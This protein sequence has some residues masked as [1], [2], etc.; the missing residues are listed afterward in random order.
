[1]V[2][3]LRIT[4]PGDNLK[5]SC[6]ETFYFFVRKTSVGSVYIKVTAVLEI[7]GKK[8]PLI[9]FSRGFCELFK[10]DIL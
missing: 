9:L 10:F 3:L 7:Y 2:L 8:L 1:M 6:F 5:N 4:L